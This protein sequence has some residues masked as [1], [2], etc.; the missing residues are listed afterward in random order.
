MTF[1]VW[2]L[3]TLTLLCSIS[4]T[5]SSLWAKPP[6]RLL[7]RRDLVFIA[8]A[9]VMNTAALTIGIVHYYCSYQFEIATVDSRLTQLAHDLASN[10]SNELTELAYVQ[11]TMTHSEAFSTTYLLTRSAS[12]DRTGT[13]KPLESATNIFDPSSEIN[14][15][16]RAEVAALSYS[17]PFFDYIFWTDS[18]GG[19]LVKWATRGEV[20]SQSQLSEYSWFSTLASGRLHEA[21]APENETPELGCGTADVHVIPRYSPKTGEYQTLIAAP[22]AVPNN[23]RTSERATIIDNCSTHRPSAPEGFSV[24]VAPM[25]SVNKP[26][27]PVFVYRAGSLHKRCWTWRISG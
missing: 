19:Q 2:A 25:I 14:P 11:A 17:F 4:W 13:A 7:R 20:T 26:V 18:L 10:V 21:R 6:L 5:I 16:F 24:L 15:R 3:L 22:F 12:T 9:A 8:V 27:L 1:V 23:T